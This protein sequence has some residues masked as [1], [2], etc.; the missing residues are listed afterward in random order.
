MDRRCTWSSEDA[1]QQIRLG[2][3]R[4]SDFGRFFDVVA[5]Y[6]DYRMT[7]EMYVWN[8]WLVAAGAVVSRS[9]HRVENDHTYGIGI[10]A[11]HHEPL[12]EQWTA[13]IELR[14]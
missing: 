2:A 12:S 14:R 10:K 8:W 9:T 11:R 3:A 7:H 4:Q 1:R 13:G 5:A 6:H